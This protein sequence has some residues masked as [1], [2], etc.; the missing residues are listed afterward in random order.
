MDLVNSIIKAVRILDII[1]EKGPLTYIEILK[2]YPLPKSTL[3]KILST[4]EAEE[5]IH[6]G[7]DRSRYHLGTKLI[8]W[9]GVARSSLEIRTISRP[10]LKK[11]QEKLDF[12]VHL[13]VV[14]HGE[15]LP[16]ESMESGNWYWHHFRYPVAIGIPAPMYATGAGKAILAFLDQNEIDKIISEK[17]MEKFTETTITDPVL[18]RVELE[19]IRSRGY[20]VSNAEHDELIRSVAA[21][22][23]NNDGRVI[24]AISVLGLVS[25]ITPER[26]PGIAEQVV[27]AAKEISY[28]LGYRQ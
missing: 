2:L 23:Y 4:L 22:I 27:E 8:E 7:P 1:K 17:G 10:I 9:G 20:A 28:L 19:K 6:R 25:R 24:A 14:A 18:L 15:V 13:T 12:T 11:L 26:V 21:P 5:L 3:F 16:I